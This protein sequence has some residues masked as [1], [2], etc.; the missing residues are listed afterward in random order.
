MGIPGA[1]PVDRLTHLAQTPQASLVSEN[2]GSLSRSPIRT[3]ARASEQAS[4]EQRQAR[5][6]PVKR[7]V[8]R[9]VGMQGTLSR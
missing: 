6:A 4:K 8:T 1:V 2:P 3:I 7:K 5:T 9:R